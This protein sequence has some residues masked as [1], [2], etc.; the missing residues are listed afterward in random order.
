MVKKFEQKIPL[1]N[2]GLVYEIPKIPDEKTID[3]YFLSSK[4]Q[5]FQKQSF[6]SDEEFKKLN[7]ESQME[8]LTRELTRRLEGYWFFN[9]GIP[10]YI[11]GSHYFYLNYWYMAAITEDGMPDYRWAQTKWAYF[12]DLCEKDPL[13][14]GGIMLSQKRFSKTEFSLA[15]IYNTATLIENDC[16]FGLQ[17][18]NAI[19][20]KNNLFK[21]RIMRS[22]RRIP[23]YLKPT[24]ND[25]KGKKEITSELTFIGEKSGASYRG[26]LSNVIDWRP[27]LASAYQ[28]KRPREVYIDEAGTIEEMDIIEAQ[29]TIKQQLQIGKKAFGKMFIPATLESMTP[30]GAPLYFQIWD[31]SNPAEKDLNGRTKSWLYRYFNPQYEG[32]ED[33]I[34]EYGN[35]LVDEAKTFRKN[36][37]DI[38]T[39]TGQTKIKRQY[40]ET[41]EEAFGASQGGE[42]WEDDTLEILKMQK[43]AVLNA[44][45]PNNKY[46]IVDFGGKSEL[47]LNKN[48]DFS[49]LEPVKQ[50]CKY[51]LLIDGIN[52]GKEV[53]NTEGSKFACVVV[54]TLDPTGTQ[55]LAIAIYCERPRTIE[56]AHYKVLGL[57]KHYNQFG[58]VEVIQMEA[59]HGL[60]AFNTFMTKEGYHHLIGRAKDLSGKGWTNKN[61]L[62]QQRTQHIIQFQYEMGNV[63]IR[64]YPQ[65]LQ[66]IELIDELLTPLSVDSH[67]TDAWLQFF[68]AFPRFDEKPKYKP[69]PPQRMIQTVVWENGK[70]IRKEVSI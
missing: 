36:E 34:D 45:V 6:L 14:F 27:T 30:K 38:A 43:Q 10:T 48:G 16:L 53:G 50:Q 8:I 55:Y 66:M 12:Y 39:P 2:D 42:R 47:K 57:L 9:N 29:T 19:E 35:S 11:T 3:G 22:H 32:R 37:L 61:N 58:G 4:K 24:S 41:I 70:M 15:H 62:G 28:G 5:K 17:S 63:F 18:L 69:P 20:A 65:S 44:D 33:F 13:C 56:Q 64:K 7:K 1:Y 59:N 25:A 23:N 52:K 60:D 67:I 51:A 68:C 40:P 31:D 26:G 54:K 21:G 46:T 49:I